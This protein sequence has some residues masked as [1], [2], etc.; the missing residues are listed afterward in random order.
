MRFHRGPVALAIGLGG[1][2]TA[3]VA[4]AAPSTIEHGAA[5]TEPA[6][7]GESVQVGTPPQPAMATY[8]VRLEI[9]WSGTTHPGTLPPNSHISPPVVVGHGRTGDLF[10]SGTLASPGMEAMAERGATDTLRDELAA[11]PTVSSVQVGSSLFGAGSQTYTVVADRSSGDLVS[12]VT[13][14]A[15]SPDW[16]VGVAD[17]DLFADDAWVDELSIDL[18]AYDAGTDSAPGFVHTN[19]DTRPAEPIS[20]PRDAA[21]ASAVAEGRFGTVSFTRVS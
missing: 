5:A 6:D 3:G 21:F 1:A 8:V 14:L 4:F 16:F 9:E 10:A 7:R 11:N 12:L 20:G 13:M 18:G 17:V 19:S 2:L 15:P